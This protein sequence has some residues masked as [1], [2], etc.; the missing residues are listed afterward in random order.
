MRASPLQRRAARHAKRI[1]KIC[2]INTMHKKTVNKRG[3]RWQR[4]KR[5]MERI[6]RIAAL[7]FLRWQAR[8]GLSCQAVARVLGIPAC[9][10]TAWKQ[11]WKSDRLPAQKIGRPEERPDAVIRNRI[12]ELFHQYG[13]GVGL[14]TLQKEFPYVSRRELEDILRRYRNLCRKKKSLLVY[15]LRWEYA[16]A[17][18][19]MDYTEPPLPVDGM[20]PYILVVRD[21]ASGKV[22]WSQPVMEKTAQ[23]TIDLLAALF[24]WY[25]PPLVI[26]CD[27]DGAFTEEGVGRLLEKHGVL[28][29]LS[30]PR[31]PEYNGACEAGIGSIKL[32][33][34]LESARHDRSGQWT[35][36]DIEA[37]RLMANETARPRGHLSPTPNEAWDAREPITPAS[38]AAFKET[39]AEEF[40]KACNELGFLPG[41]ER[42]PNRVPRVRNSAAAAPSLRYGRGAQKATADRIAISQ[43]LDASGFLFFKRRRFS[44]LKKRRFWRKIS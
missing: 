11:R 35:C 26:K 1:R 16:G 14:P 17:V 6:I 44:L 2:E 8:C 7:A 9:T 4:E 43:T 25:G 20:Y 39:Y 31:M 5:E 27:N 41:L 42:D 34:H 10:L 32:R 29:L 13:P 3:R 36:D 15:A 23:Q 18:W 22:L 21:L 37:A 12:I 33:A 28:C 24:A 30:P 40:S 19:A 38:R